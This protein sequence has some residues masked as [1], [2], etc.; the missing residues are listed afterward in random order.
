MGKTRLLEALR[1]DATGFASSTPCARRTP[2]P[3]R[4]RSGASSAGVHGL[5]TGRSRRG[6]RGAPARR[7]RGTGA[8]LVPWLP[9][10]AIAFGLEFAPTPEVEMLAEKNRR[11]KLH[12]V[13]GRFL[14]VMMPD[15]TLIEIENAHHMD[16]ARP[17]CSLT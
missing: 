16:E 12:E 2:L 15:P 17:S 1:D 10:I 13:V 5:R 6:Y 3:R 8:D 9:L 14:D 11:A 7:G 4:M